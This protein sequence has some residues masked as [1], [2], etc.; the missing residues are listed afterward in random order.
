MGAEGRTLKKM[1]KKLKNCAGLTL[2]ETLIT[3][4]I[5][6][7]VAG[8]MAGGIPAA[9]TAY[10]KAVDAANAHVALS[11]TVNALRMELSTAD[12]VECADESNTVTYNSSSTGA[13]TRLYLDGDAIMVQD[14]A[15][16]SGEEEIKNLTHDLVSK[17]AVTSALKVTYE[18][19]SWADSEKKDVLHFKDVSAKKGDATIETIE[20]IY[21]RV[22]YDQFKIPET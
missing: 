1:M 21:I 8:V 22:V 11:T 12:T 5:L 20:D 2:A 4:L 13:P 17:T 14:F 7:M 16:Y 19:V 18:T 3:V 10:S 6:V 9:V 15:D